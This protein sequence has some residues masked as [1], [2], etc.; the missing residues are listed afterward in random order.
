MA[1]LELIALRWSSLTP[2]LK[3]VVI[4]GV[5][6]VVFWMLRRILMRRLNRWASQTENEN[7][8]DDRLVH[9]VSRFYGVPPKTRRCCC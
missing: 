1:I 3:S 5:C 7:D 4:V 9:F 8:L 6:I 2:F